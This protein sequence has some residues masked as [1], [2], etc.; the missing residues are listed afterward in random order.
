MMPVAHYQVGMWR[1]GGRTSNHVHRRVVMTP[2]MIRTAVVLTAS[3]AHVVPS[4]GAPA[5]MDPARCRER[6]KV[7]LQ[8]IVSLGLDDRAPFMPHLSITR[9]AR[10]EFVVAPVRSFA[11]AAVFD[12]SGRLMRIVGGKGQGFSAINA[13]TRD[14]SGNTYLF[15]AGRRRLSVLDVNMRLVHHVPT[16]SQ[17]FRAEVTNKGSIIAN[18]ALR[19]SESFGLPLH[20]LEPTGRVTASFGSQVA[21]V[22]IDA[23]P[24]M[25]RLMVIAESGDAVWSLAPDGDSVEKWGIAGQRLA[26][27]GIERGSRRPSDPDWVQALGMD[28][29]I[30]FG[31]SSPEIRRDCERVER[32]T[33]TNFRVSRRW[34]GGPESNHRCASSTPSAAGCS[35]HRS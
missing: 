28:Q 3:V 1:A 15:D 22:P 9:G 18:M 2:A 29:T 32:T 14:P 34:N 35:K 27:I 10:G 24:R 19:T 23:A 31:S 20:V 13:V 17:V 7:V 12:S 30:A 5:T 25:Q 6:C 11:E 33:S 26:S 16:P 4:Q 21:D 8:R